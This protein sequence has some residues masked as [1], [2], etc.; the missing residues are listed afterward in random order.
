MSSLLDTRDAV[1]SSLASSPLIVGLFSTPVSVT[2]HG[3]E[4]STADLERYSK[5]TPALI[6]ALLR[7]DERIEG[8][9]VTGDATFGVIA[10][11][12]NT[13][14]LRRDRSVVMLAD[15]ATRVIARSF[16]GTGVSR[17]KELVGRN[18]YSAKIDAQDISM[19]SLTWRQTIDLADDSNAV[20]LNT[21]DVKYDLA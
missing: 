1:V 3:G 18:E 21:L 2:A 17:A 6:V 15:A 16:F 19:W 8:G 4:F 14:A 5:Q 11:T 12:K 7:Y 10:M 9:L 20:P 13:P